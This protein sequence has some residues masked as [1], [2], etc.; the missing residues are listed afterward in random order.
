MYPEDEIKRLISEDNPEAMN[1][2]FDNYY[3]LLCICSMRN[4]QDIA[5]AEDIVQDVMVSF[6]T[7][8][9]G[10]KFEGSIRA[11]FFT[12]VTKASFKYAS[13]K[14]TINFNDV[15]SF[16]DKQFEKLLEQADEERAELKK[17]LEAEINKLPA[18]SREVFNLV[19]TSNMSYGEV[20]HKLGITVN[21][22]KTLYYNSIRK[23]RE[24]IKDDKL[25]ILMA[26]AY[27]L[28]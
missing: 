13:R 25:F 14:R 20:G 4:L 16:V 12:A 18:R 11:Y 24:N 21:T 15:E 19:V 7:N 5:D 28:K 1:V 27:F 22:V 26:L 23:L 8:K 10:K 3:T 6:W 2:I 9:R 17:L